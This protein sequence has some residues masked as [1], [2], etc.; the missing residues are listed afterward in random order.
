M[1]K[2][3]RLGRWLFAAVCLLPVLVLLLLSFS[4]QWAYPFVFPQSLTTEAWF[5]IFKPDNKIAQSI[6]TSALIAVCVAS[7]ATAMGFF[8]SGVIATHRF[9]KHLLLMAYLPFVLSPVIFAVC[10]KYFFIR[11]QLA[12]TWSGV[13]LA[14]L[15]IA[16]PYSIIF[17]I[18]FWNRRMQ[19]YQMLVQTLGGTTWQTFQKVIFPMALPMLI[20]GF[21]Q[22]F[23]I[24]WFEYGLT[25]V[26]GFGKVQS[27]TI[28]VFQ[29]ITEA[30]IFYASLSC[31]LLILPPIVLLWVNKKFI[32]HKLA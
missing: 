15:I 29:Y 20:V 6:F 16:Y 23:L 5:Y 14:Q 32:Y 7:L 30:N 27:L 12:G 31:C 10:I 9:K 13:I 11:L 4:Q 21:F 28:R 3:L 18:S 17:F 19:Q 2:R 25:L 22:C 24:S 1:L 26:I 8:T